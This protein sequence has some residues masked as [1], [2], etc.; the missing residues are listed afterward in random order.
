MYVTNSR[1]LNCV[2]T[3]LKSS[4]DCVEFEKDDVESSVVCNSVVTAAHHNVYTI[5]MV[6]FSARFGGFRSI[7]S[8]G[9][10]CYLMGKSRLNLIAALAAS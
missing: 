8:R 3:E 10:I 1:P 7:F 2:R 4:L 9:Y 5:R 6:S